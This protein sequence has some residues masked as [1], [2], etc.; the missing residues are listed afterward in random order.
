[1][2]VD[3]TEK[4][5]PSCRAFHL[6]MTVTYD[7]GPGRGVE[8]SI[9]WHR[10]TA[11][12]PRSS[13]EIWTESPSGPGRTSSQRSTPNGSNRRASR[14]APRSPRASRT[15]TSPITGTCRYVLLARRR[16]EDAED[17]VS[18]VFDRAYRAWRSGHGPAGR[19]LPWLL[20]IAR[21]IIV[22]RWRR[23]RILRWLPL[24]DA[25]TGGEPK[26]PEDAGAR[27]EFW[28]WLDRLA[29]ALPERQ[30]EIVLLRYQR[31]LSDED[32]GEI[33]GLSASGVRSLLSRALATLR[34]HPELWS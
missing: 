33:L 28:M 25:W 18:D 3:R 14:A 21:R 17:I 27:A 20:L 24:P 15:S 29:D 34:H 31:D 12:A 16:P 11:T 8:R 23:E 13:D 19:T 7:E 4:V 1:V 22:D 26:D 5:V 10:G 30:R 9:P 32:I 6:G 2:F